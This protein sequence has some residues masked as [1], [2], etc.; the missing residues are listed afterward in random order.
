MPFPRRLE[1][2]HQ[3]QGQGVPRRNSTRRRSSLWS[4][5]TSARA[6][7]GIRRSARRCSTRR[8]GPIPG[9][10]GLPGQDARRHLGD[11][12]V[13]AQRVGADALRPAEA[14]RGTA[15]DLLT[16]QRDYDPVKLGLE[17]DRTKFSL[18]PVLPR[19]P[20]WT[21]ASRGNWN[22]GHEWSFLSVTHRRERYDIIEYLKTYNTEPPNPGSPPEVDRRQVSRTLRRRLLPRSGSSCWSSPCW[23]G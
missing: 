14:G 21:R 9:P 7:S 2:D 3:G 6:R 23:H 4:S 20:R 12:A 11:G 5:G 19:V 10:E 17:T 8:S 13:P 22:T 18:P 16:G 15:G 1:L